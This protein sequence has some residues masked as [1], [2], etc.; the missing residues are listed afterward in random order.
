MAAIDQVFLDK[1]YER[2]HEWSERGELAEWRERKKQEQDARE[3]QRKSIRKSIKQ[4]Q[5]RRQELMDILS[6]PE[7][8]KTKQMRI[9]YAMQVAGLEGKITEFENELKTLPDTE[10]NATLYRIWD[11]I[12]ALQQHWAKLP[13][14]ERLIVI[15]AFTR[16]VI[17]STPSLGWLKMEVEWK[18][19]EKDTMHERRI[20]NGKTWTDEEKAIIRELWPDGD[21]GELL[22]RL[23]DRS[24]SAIKKRA[25]DMGV[26]RDKKGGSVRLDDYFDISLADMEYA[27]EHQLDTVSKTPQWSALLCG[28]SCLSQALIRLRW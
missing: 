14:D 9:D 3:E 12:P 26:R 11:L 25:G 10:D 16:R 27:R 19:G 28:Q 1:F 8:P 18:I 22:S 7:I 4:A 6:D 17:V 2:L 5:A 24:Y 13:F 21:G 23:P 20:T 15:G